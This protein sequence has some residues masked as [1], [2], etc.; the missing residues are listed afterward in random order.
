GLHTLVGSEGTGYDQAG[1]DAD[2]DVEIDAVVRLKAAVKLPDRLDDPQSATYGP[3]G[4]VLMRRRESEPD[5]GAVAGIVVDVA[6]KTAYDGRADAMISSQRLAQLLGIQP[7]GEP[8]R[9][10]QITE[11]A[12]QLPPLRLRGSPPG[13]AW[14]C[15]LRERQRRSAFETE[16]GISRILGIAPGAPHHSPPPPCHR[17]T[18]RSMPGLNIRG[19]L[20]TSAAHTTPHARWP[21][22]ALTGSLPSQTQPDGD[23]WPS[24]AQTDSPVDQLHECRF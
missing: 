19:L 6:L 23:L 10:H 11:Q 1:V 3:L 7:F 12:R 17:V 5:H 21:G 22:A 20:E 13:L 14:R 2:P 9:V 15:R 16:F 4:V 8:N 18:L 24:D